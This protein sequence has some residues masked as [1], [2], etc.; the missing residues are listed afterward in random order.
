MDRPSTS[1]R[2]A[3]PRAPDD[4]PRIPTLDAARAFA[5]VA[6]VFGHTL[7]AL[8]APAVR[9]EPLVAAYWV[10]RGFTAPLFMVVAGWAVTVATSRSGAR[11]LA[12]VRTRLPRVLLLFALGYALRWPGWG[13]SLLLRGDGVVWAH[14]L[15][16]DALHAIGAALLASTFV[17][18]LPWSDDRKAGV[19]GALVLLSVGLGIS[20]LV[21]SDPTALPPVRLALAQVVGGTST[22]PLFPWVGYFFV[23]GIL[24]LAGG[25]GR[26]RRAFAVAMVGATLAV[27]GLLES[28]R[29]GVGD[30]RL[31]A[32]R[33]GTV[34]VLL[35]ALSTI[36]A[37]LARGVRP[38]GR[39]SLA[40]YVIHLPLVYGWSTQ[41]GLL[42]RI[43]PRL[44]IGTALAIGATVLVGS[45]ALRQVLARSARALKA[46]AARAGR[47]GRGVVARR[48]RLMDH[49][50]SAHARRRSMAASM[51][52]RGGPRRCASCP[53]RMRWRRG[54]PSAWRRPSGSAPSRRR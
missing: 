49:A 15:A 26:G 52:R 54:R 47:G 24:G 20:P 22:F 30:P 13:T 7:D 3:L 39:A 12:I 14:L 29:L 11:G 2:A 43:G 33:S 9:G 51:R 46:T 32:L 35:A 36:P 53:P 1:T 45:L 17:L 41:E 23:G 8:L 6:M 48:A 40:V 44:P 19:F 28:L 42:Q 34:L 27:P 4:A 38:L 5:V 18:A 21:P 10:A 50:A 31:F 16:F 25:V 37:A